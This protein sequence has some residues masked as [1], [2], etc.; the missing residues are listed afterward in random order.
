MRRRDERFAKQ[1]RYKLLPDPLYNN[2][3]TPKVRR[4]RQ[5]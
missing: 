3:K 5:G 4:I 1:P 2:K